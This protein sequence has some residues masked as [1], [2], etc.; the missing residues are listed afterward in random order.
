MAINRWDPFRDVMTLNTAMDSLLR[1]AFVPARAGSVQL[2]SIAWNV[3]ESAD[4]FWVHAAVPG[5]QPDQL[6]LIINE[7]SLTIRGEVPAP[8]VPEGAQFR[9]QEWGTQ[10][11]ERSLQFAVPLHA[12]AVQAHYEQGILTLYLPKAETAKPRRITIQR[13]AQQLEGHATESA[14]GH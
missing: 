9:L 6:D 4:A 11:F 14:T 5:V 1:D 2:P 8:A 7:Q 13:Q 12:D 10:R 3:A